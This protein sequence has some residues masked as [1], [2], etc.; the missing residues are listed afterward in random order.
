MAHCRRVG[1][2]AQ[3]AEAVSVMI[4][5]RRLRLGRHP[6]R[7]QTLVEMP[8]LNCGHGERRAIDSP[9]R[10]L[11]VVDGARRTMWADSAVRRDS[12]TAKTWLTICRH[13]CGAGLRFWPPT[14][15]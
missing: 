14:G 15:R 13:L 12:G 3:A 2:L 8:T 6:Y 11:H 1:C 10:I 9:K 4:K 7:R 5:N